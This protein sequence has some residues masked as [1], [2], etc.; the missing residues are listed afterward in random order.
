MENNTFLEQIK[1]A[2]RNHRIINVERLILKQIG[3]ENFEE[4]LSAVG[5]DIHRVQ[6]VSDY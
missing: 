6:V 1:F 2:E 5:A 3:Y 4:K